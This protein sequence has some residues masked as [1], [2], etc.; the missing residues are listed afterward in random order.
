MGNFN[1]QTVRKYYSR[2]STFL[3]DYEKKYM[4]PSGIEPATDVL[5]HNISVA[6]PTLLSSSYCQGRIFHTQTK[7]TQSVTLSCVLPV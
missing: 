6:L 2:S 5:C 1:T 7:N 4:S 3:P